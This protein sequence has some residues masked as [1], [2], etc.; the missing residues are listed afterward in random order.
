M[1]RRKAVRRAEKWRHLMVNSLTARIKQKMPGF[2]KGQKLIAN[3]INEHYD[4]VAFMTASKLGAT[5]GVSESTV[6]R[7]A[8]E[9]GYAGYPELQRAI[10]EMIR[11]KMTSLQRLEMMSKSHDAATVM[12]A[13]F[14]KDMETIRHTMEETSREAF[15]RAADAIVTAKKV[16]IIGAR[17]SSALAAFLGYYFHLILD[18]VQLVSVTSE[19]QM[20]EQMIRIGK[21]DAVLGISFPRYSCRA[22]KALQFA[23]SQGATVI[24]ITDS[25]TSPIAACADCVLLARSDMVAFVDSLVAPLSLINAL[26]VSTAIKKK[27]EVKEVLEKLERI[28]D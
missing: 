24:A 6:V 8:T 25:E 20:F 10:Q 16:Y 14:D 2:S 12:E 23:S 15:D 1:Y 4:T 22:A 7:F 11:S 17:S 13:V 28:W 26:I 27:G 19:A 3:Y 21:D 9:I 5:V 18:H